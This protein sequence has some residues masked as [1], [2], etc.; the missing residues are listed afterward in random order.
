ML[1]GGT[2]GAQLLAVLA[3]PILTRLYSPESFGML[4]VFVSIVALFSVIAGLKYELAIPL[5]EDER[6][7]AALTLLALGIILT[8]VVVSAFFVYWWSDTLADFIGTPELENLLWLAPFAIAFS[9]MYQLF[10]YW[11]IRL[12]EFPII[13]RTKIRQQIVT[14]VMQVSLFKF[15]SMGL[16]I[17]NATGTGM[18]VVTLSKKVFGR[19]CWK[20]TPGKRLGYVLR[21]YKNFPIYSTWGAFLNTAGSQVPP[22]LFASTFGAGYAGLYALAHRLIAMPMG[23]IGQA[24]GQ[25]FLS[26]ASE[27]YRSG[28]L[29]STLNKTHKILIK[30]I[31]PPTAIFILFGPSLFGYIFG[32]EWKLSGEVASWLSL[33]MLMGF[34][35]SPLSSVF[36]VAEKQHLGMLMQALLLGARVSGIGLGVLYDDFMLAVIFFSIFNV[37]GYLVYQIVSFQVLGMSWH[38]PVKNYIPAFTMLSALIVMDMYYEM[39]SN[40]LIFAAFVILSGAYYWMLAKGIRHD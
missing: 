19:E 35:T 8:V 40:F 25:V 11:A 2:T 7:A 37:F 38:V 17:G 9:G 13:A 32:N 36:I 28:K 1:V 31:L 3:A 26:D 30:C 27:Q 6:D 5:P 22:L 15:G 12:K 18:G 33:W 20:K 23:L 14:I 29:S 39:N 10:T 4:A 34:T 24:V 21:R 16:L